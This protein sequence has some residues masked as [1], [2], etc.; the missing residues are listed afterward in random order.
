MKIGSKVKEKIARIIGAHF[1]T[2]EI[3]NV[4]TEANIETDASLYAKWR[5]TLDAFSKVKTE[6]AFFSLIEEFC[7]PLN[8]SEPQIRQNFIDELNP[9]LAFE[10]VF[11]EPSERSAKV[12][13]LFL[14]TPFEPAESK[15]DD[16]DAYVK[17]P[18]INVGNF[19]QKVI[20]LVCEEFLKHLSNYEVR[21][22]IRPIIQK[23]DVM[24][25]QIFVKSYLDDILDETPFDTFEDVLQTIRR[26]DENADKTL[27]TIFTALL[28]P[29][30][31]DADE[32]KAEEIA[33]KIGKYL[34]YDKFYIQQMGNDFEVL[35]E[36]EMDEI[37]GFSPADQE[38]TEREKLA[39]IEAIKQNKEL[40]K[41]LR[42][43]HQVYMDVIDTFCQD[44]KNPTKQLNDAYLFLVK[45]IEA[46]LQSLGLKQNK[47]FF[48]KPFKNDLYTAE[49]EWNGSGTSHTARNTPRLSWD[50]VRPSLYK[51]HSDITNLNN[52]A[53]EDIDMTDD[54]KKLEEIT[55]LISEKRIAKIPVPEAEKTIKMEITK[56]PDLNV[57]TIEN[58]TVTKGKKAIHL[59]KFSPTEWS[60]A[61]IRFITDN[62]VYIKAGQKTSTADFESLGFRNDKTGKPN[63]AWYFL[64]GLA[65]N[66]GQTV[67]IKSPIPDNIKQQKRTL[68]DRLKTIFKNDTDPFNDF[69]EDNT[70]RIK[71]N[72]LPPN[73]QKDTDDLGV[74]DYL[75]KTM[76]SEE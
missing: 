35:S 65:K 22:I 25:H 42:E 18:D 56:M 27:T 30:N 6:D 50:A 52:I 70:Y 59:P 53:E 44:S 46:G 14:T 36:A 28:H 72:L 5:I 62:D 60:N 31:Y 7:H 26:K 54:E 40:I 20:H 1:S 68:S 51:V 12:L 67:V 76:L 43:T 66:N 45:K 19:S 58:N 49:I 48:Y 39:D 74:D 69:S 75:K 23:D 24:M 17:L 10:D 55:N 3:V 9:I 11:I 8:F 32:E 29:L 71:I 73:E 57:N 33:E 37:H 38:Q 47:V 2:A 61:E 21:K 34:K 15:P 13:P 63:T 16:E 41:S 64:L 4:F